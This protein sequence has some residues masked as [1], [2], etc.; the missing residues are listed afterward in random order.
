[1]IT[2]W[3]TLPHTLLLLMSTVV[4]M[5]QQV[6]P[7]QQETR[8]NGPGF[9]V[10][11][12]AKQLKKAEKYPEAAMKALEAARIFQQTPDWLAWA[13]SYEEAYMCARFLGSDTFYRDMIVRFGAAEKRLSAEKGVPAEA[14][15]TIWGRTGFMH[16]SLGEYDQAIAYYEKAFPFAAQTTD[17]AFQTRLYGSAAMLFWDRGDDYRALIYHEKAL[18]LAKAKQDTALMAAITA[19]LANVWRTAEPQ[20]AIAAYR[21]ALALDPDNS[22]TLM[23]LSKAYLELE[24]NIAKAFETARASLRLAEGDAEKSDALHQLGRVYFERREY[25]KALYHYDQALPNAVAGYG[26]GHPE[27]V[28]IHAFRGHALLAKK[29]FV[30]A[31]GAFNQTL[32]DLLP[33]FSPATADQNPAIDELTTTSLWI[34]EALLGKARVYEQR[35]RQSSQTGD[36]ERSLA[37]AE[38][39][40]AYLHKIKLRYGDD[41]SKFAMNDFAQSACEAALRSAFALYR[42]TGDRQHAARAF[43]ISEQTKAAVLGEALYKKEVKR[44][45]GVPTALLEQERKCH[46]QIAFFEQNLTASDESHWKDSLFYARRQREDLEKQLAENY[47]AYSAALSGY[48]A[49]VSPDEVRQQIPADAALLEYFLGDSS[50]YTFL[51]TTDTFWVQEQPLPT[52]F[53]TTAAAFR[54]AA[55]DWQFASDSSAIASGVFLQT[56]YQ[57]YK[58]LLEKP[59]TVTDKP[60]LFIVPDGPLHYLSFELLLTRDYDGRWVDRDVPFLLQEKSVSYRF[61]GK[62]NPVRRGSKGWGGFGTEYDDNTLSAIEWP[63]MQQE[64]TGVALRNNGKLPYAD[65]EIL[66]IAGILGGATWLNQQATRENFLKNAERYGILHLAMHGFVD[67]KSPLRSRL[68]FTQSV[69][70]EDPFVYA[71]DLYNLQLTAGLA[72]LSACQSGT[73]AW[74]RGEGVMSLARAFAFAGCPSMVMSLW[75]VSDRSSSELMVAFYRELKAGKNKDEALRLAKLRYLQMVSP[76][77]AKPVYWAGFVPVGEMEGLPESYFSDGH[78]H[79]GRLLALGLAVSGLLFL[80]YRRFMR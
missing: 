49:S 30:P 66:A 21:Q 67:E 64:N 4:F 17:S 35:F 31:L 63:D 77:Y 32:D 76:E 60:R 48:R 9:D 56:G 36:L 10:L 41:R 25:D 14:K 80:L 1:M 50:M 22:E 5:G 55:G 47:P 19:N 44:I 12:Q 3:K 43:A 54:R 78:W 46:E 65:D 69:A 39:A 33:L 57:L 6:Q 62:S 20:R 24:H 61:S 53:L 59:L 79:W 73:G 26:A 28:K 34:M 68:L 42:S 18:A 37:C 23:L 58:W 74:K 45:A 11:E 40:L 52:D 38:Q 8:A 29:E 70:Q 72:I 16:H 51:L 71:S 2:W 27:C 75:N 13:A 15:S 7:P